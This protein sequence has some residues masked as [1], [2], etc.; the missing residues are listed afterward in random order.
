M[1]PLVQWRVRSIVAVVTIALGQF[2][3]APPTLSRGGVDPLDTKLAIQLR[4]L[5]FTRG[6]LL[7]IPLPAMAG[8][9]NP[10]SEADRFPTCRE[11]VG[12]LVGWLVG[13]QA[14]R[15]SGVAVLVV[16]LR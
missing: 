3:F 9:L 15:R 11:L 10:V 12:W 7:G 14:T 5:G 6:L 4:E 16:D 1:R 2:V 8:W 13:G